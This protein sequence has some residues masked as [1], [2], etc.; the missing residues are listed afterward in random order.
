VYA[1]CL[2]LDDADRRR[3]AETG[4]AIS[5][6]PSS[7]LFLG[8]GLFDLARADALGLRIGMGTDIGAGT[9]FSMLATL[10]EAYK[11]LQLNS[12]RLSPQRAFYLAT[13]GGARSLYLDD[14]IGNFE[15]GKEADFVV[16][17]PHA[18]PL[19]ARRMSD[20]QTLAERLF[21]LMMLGDDRA[22]AATH[23]LG[24]CA[25]RR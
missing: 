5:F 12:Q 8:S 11:V 7:N 21:V 3:M 25:W 17:D 24:E 18:T 2:W 23:I 20:T 9:S 15:C 1:H 4:A 6:C 19:L 22:V 13:L 10:N 14:R 16:L